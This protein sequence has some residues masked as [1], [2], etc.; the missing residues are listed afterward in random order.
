MRRVLVT[1]GCGFI[2]NALVRVLLQDSNLHVLNLDA[3][4][5]AA[6]PEGLSDLADDPRYSFVEGDVRDRPTLDAALLR[7]QP[8]G[9]IHLAAE[10]HVDRSIDNPRS[11]LDT[12]V[13]GTVTLLQAATRYWL[14]LSP[15]RKSAFR[16]VHVSTD[17]V[18]GSLAPGAPSFDPATRYDPRSPYSASKA[19]ADHFVR[20]WHAT[21]GLPAMVTNCSNNF[22]PWQFPEKFIPV[23]VLR[24]STREPVPIYGQG[25][26]IR[27]WIYVEDHASGLVSALSAGR[28]GA[29]YL[30]GCRNEWTNRD[31]AGTICDLIDELLR[32]GGP[33]RRELLTSVVDRPGHDTRYAIEPS[34][35]EQ[36]LG[37]RGRQ[38]FISALRGT[39]QWYLD[40]REW[41]DEKLRRTGGYRRLG[42]GTPA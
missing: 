2:G 14:S 39:I 19:A 31:L 5:Y 34:L 8:D 9:V 41:V 15:E 16:F 38:E 27:D 6:V 29:T 20:A 18:F 28:P 36:E 32:D 11:F 37:W 24:A 22:G 35:A 21:Y 12:N 13:E 25:D 1:G 7:F 10:T 33:P 40:H 30:F 3:H 42:M 26:Q 4:T 23:V 17:E